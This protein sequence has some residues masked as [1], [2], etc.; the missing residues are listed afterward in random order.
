M[1]HAA[2]VD[3][4]DGGQVLEDVVVGGERRRGY[5]RA[6]RG[7]SARDTLVMFILDITHTSTYVVIVTYHV[8]GRAKEMALS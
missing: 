4:V 8:Q 1:V 3:G 5:G 2:V 7:G 6:E